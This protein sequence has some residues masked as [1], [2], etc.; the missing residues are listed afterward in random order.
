MFLSLWRRIWNGGLDPVRGRRIRGARPSSCPLRV[1]PLED[2]ELPAVWSAGLPVAAPPR[3]A[4]VRVLGLMPP[5]SGPVG[6]SLVSAAGASKPPEAAAGVEP[7]MATP[8]GNRLTVTVGEDA[9]ATVIDLGAVF[10]GMQGLRQQDGL[11]LAM[12]GNTNPTLVKTDL[13]EAALTLTF[14]SGKYGA[15]TVTVCATD[16]DGVSAKETLLIT[17]LPRG[18]AGGRVESPA[19]T[20]G[21][22]G[23]GTGGPAR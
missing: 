16:A 19:P 3:V 13:S 23:A 9:A 2:R 18:A 12:L 5:P 22:D 21:M 14:A 6:G 8:G 4:A 17:V 1:E 20:R 11:Q 10:G 7:I 15:A